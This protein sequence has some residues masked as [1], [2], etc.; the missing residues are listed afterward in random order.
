MQVRRDYLGWK[1]ILRMVLALGFALVAFI[2]T[3]LVPDVAFINHDIIRLLITVFFGLVGFSIFPDLA[4][5]TSLIV[6]SWV[7]FITVK[8]SSEVMDQLQRLP[9]QSSVAPLPYSSHAPVGGVSVNQ[10]LVLDTSAIID[11]RFVDIAKAGFLFGTILIPSFVLSE[12]QQVADS[13][14]YLKRSRGRR[15]FEIIDDLKKVKGIRVEVWDKDI[16]AKTVDD[17]LLKLTK[18]LNGKII[19][20]DFNLN[21]VASVS[22][23]SVLNINDLANAVKTV[24]IPGEELKIKVIHVGKDPKQGV[25]YLNDGTMV[26][27]EDGAT[28]VGRDIKTEVTRILQVSAGKM[29]FTKKVD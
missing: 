16:A 25:G 29:I 10:P 6:I 23:V 18:S 1:L 2:F 15:G 21:R 17:K 22:G 11:G 12:L 13:A 20:T 19:T 27:V 3:E 24:A 8:V 28:L 5:R 26:V 7:N 14:D 4:R 9:R